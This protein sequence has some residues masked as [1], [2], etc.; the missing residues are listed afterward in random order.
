MLNYLVN[1]I[2]LASGTIFKGVILIIL[3]SYITLSYFKSL[4]P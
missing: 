1:N 4:D 2:L 3:I